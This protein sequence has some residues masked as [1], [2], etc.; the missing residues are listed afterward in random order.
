[1]TQ[2]LFVAAVPTD[3]HGQSTGGRILDQHRKQR[4]GSRR[5]VCF[6]L[7]GGV[8]HPRKRA[9]LHVPTCLPQRYAL[10]PSIMP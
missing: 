2:L 9:R 7:W 4:S 5:G 3:S 6:M 10:R 8:R 1:M